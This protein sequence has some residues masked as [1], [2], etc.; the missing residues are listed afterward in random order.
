MTSLGNT[1]ATVKE[2]KGFIESL[3]D[4]EN[5]IHHAKYIYIY[6]FIIY[7]YSVIS[8]R[9]LPFKKCSMGRAKQLNEGRKMKINVYNSEFLSAFI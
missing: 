9:L 3:W 5:I 6:I 2:W 8:Q 4:A 1:E 7:I